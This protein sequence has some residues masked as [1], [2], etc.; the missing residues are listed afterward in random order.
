MVGYQENKTAYNRLKTGES[1]FSSIYAF[2]FFERSV[3]L[4]VRRYV[5][6]SVR[7]IC[8]RLFLPLALSTSVI[9]TQSFT[10]SKLRSFLPLV[11]SP[12]EIFPRRVFPR[13]YFRFFPQQLYTIK[14]T[15]C[16]FRCTFIFIALLRYFK[17]KLDH[18]VESRLSFVGRKDAVFEQMVA[19]RKHAKRLPA[20]GGGYRIKR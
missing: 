11:S 2:L 10:D 5:F 15:R 19:Y 8:I 3:A 14:K 7:P 1:P 17:A 6:G 20:F 13:R 12:D 9:K 4:A 18:I 16:I